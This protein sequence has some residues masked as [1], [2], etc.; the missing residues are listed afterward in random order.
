MLQFAKYTHGFLM[1]W[2]MFWKYLEINLRKNIFSWNIHT[3]KS[4]SFQTLVIP[5]TCHSKHLS[6][7]IL[8]LPLLLASNALANL[9]CH[10]HPKS[11][12]FEIQQL[13]V[14][15]VYCLCREKGAIHV[16]TY[17]II[18]QTL[19]QDTIPLQE[20]SGYNFWE[21]GN[22]LQFLLMLVPSK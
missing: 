15:F 3:T 2:R 12:L 10:R 9:R 7:W 11:E 19:I 1:T 6:F 17:Y 14:T 16:Q 13:I 8:T 4:L 20:I 18:L 22:Y 5:N 21:S